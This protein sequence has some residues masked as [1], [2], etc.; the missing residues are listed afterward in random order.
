[1]GDFTS[2]NAGLNMVELN[3]KPQDMVVEWGLSH[4]K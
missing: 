2:K 4:F 3:F 1:M